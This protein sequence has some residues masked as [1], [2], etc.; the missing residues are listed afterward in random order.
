MLTYHTL[1]TSMW[2]TPAERP[3]RLGIWYSATGLFTIFSGVLNYA[4]GHI[5]GSLA[6]WKYMSA[7]PSNPSSTLLMLKS[8]A[9]TLSRALSPSSGRSSSSHCC[10]THPQRRHTGSLVIQSVP[11]SCAG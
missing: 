6:P 7:T 10:R 11:F 4:I 1:V 8:E 5:T 2:Y 3:L 9:G